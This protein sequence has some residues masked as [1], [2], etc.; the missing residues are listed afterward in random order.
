MPSFVGTAFARQVAAGAASRSDCRARGDG[1]SIR[2]H[3]RPIGRAS[4]LPTLGFRQKRAQ[5]AQCFAGSLQ[6]HVLVRRLRRDMSRAQTAESQIDRRAPTLWD[7]PDILGVPATLQ[8]LLRLRGLTRKAL[9]PAVPRLPEGFSTHRS[10]QKG[11]RWRWF[12]GAQ[13]AAARCWR[14]RISVLV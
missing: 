3:R 14:S 8:W 13:P 2:H 10:H 1:R 12:S 4:G 6:A 9:K 5:Q 7:G 11:C